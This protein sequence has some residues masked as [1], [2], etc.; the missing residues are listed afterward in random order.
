MAAKYS[1]LFWCIFL[2]IFLKNLF[3]ILSHFEK[4]TLANAEY[5]KLIMDGE[6]VGKNWSGIFSKRKTVGLLNSEISLKHD[7]NWKKRV[8]FNFRL[9]SK[10]LG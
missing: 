3:L 5:F 4:Q 9:R 8:E 10:V 2:R 7:S 1:F 6:T